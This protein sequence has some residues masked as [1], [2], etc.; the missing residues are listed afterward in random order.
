[1]AGLTVNRLCGSGLEA[2][3]SAAHA[4][5]SGD[6][7]VFV[8]GGVESM[9]RAPCVMLKPEAGFERGT[10]ALVDSTLGWRF[11]NPLLDA[12]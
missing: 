5:A 10:H 7:E 2:V 6:G 8:A 1:V 11:V 3:N 12:A 9:T 4:I